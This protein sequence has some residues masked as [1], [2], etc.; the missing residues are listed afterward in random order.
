MTIVLADFPD[1]TRDVIDH[2]AAVLSRSRAVLAAANLFADR[3]QQRQTDAN[4]RA[5][6]L[7]AKMVDVKYASSAV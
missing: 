5:D 1:A 4:A 3:A 2:A 6:L 7:Q